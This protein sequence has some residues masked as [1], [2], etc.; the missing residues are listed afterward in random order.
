MQSIT[1]RLI[2]G[3]EPFPDADLGP[4]FDCTYTVEGSLIY[5]SCSTS[6]Q[7]RLTKYKT[8]SECAADMHAKYGRHYE[9]VHPKTVTQ[10]C[11]CGAKHTSNPNLHSAIM[12][13][14]LYKKGA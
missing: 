9:A 2:Q 13:C 7:R 6:N 12:P 8:L 3:Q 10:E 4:L 5:I 1:Y 14:P 11:E